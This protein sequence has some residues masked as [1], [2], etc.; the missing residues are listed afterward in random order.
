[1]PSVQYND[2][3]LDPL[4][5]TLYGIVFDSVT[6]KEY[7]VT[8]NPATAALTEV[9][10]GIDDCCTV[11]SFNAYD[12]Y[13]GRLYIMGNRFS[14]PPGSSPRLLGFDVAT[15]TLATSPFLPT[16][17]QFNVLQAAVTPTANQPPVAV[18]QDVEVTAPPG[19]CGADASI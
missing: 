5:G 14:D 12:P 4:T 6:S 3:E 11:S 16:G 17:W 18:C 10:S 8:V 9:G 1:S 7:V 19:Q 15:G 2:F 13:A